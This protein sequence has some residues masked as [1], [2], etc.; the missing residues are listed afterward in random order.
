MRYME[1]HPD[2]M[3]TD[4]EEGL[5]RVQTSNYAYLIESTTLEYYAERICNVT[6]VG[7]LIDE[8]NYAIGMRKGT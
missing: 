4:N 2:S 3:V 6:R 5:K 8:R 1:T 7:D